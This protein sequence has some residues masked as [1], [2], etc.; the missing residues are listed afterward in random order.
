MVTTEEFKEKAKQTCLERYGVEN[1]GS[2][3]EFR[4]K[5]KQTCLERYGVEN[6]LLVPE[7]REKAKQTCLEKYGTENPLMAPE[8]KEKA[9]QTFLDKYG[10]DCSSHCPEILDKIQKSSFTS[11]EY[12]LPSGKIINIQGYEYFALDELFDQSISEE[13][14]V[15]GC[16]NVPVIKY[17]DELGTDRKHFPDIFIPSQN[18]C[19]EV[20]SP[21]TYTFKTDRILLKKKYAQEAGYN[22]EIWIYDGKGGKQVV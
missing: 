2:V 4:E 19:I 3:P 12:T 20:K 8:I 6:T 13:D 21:W 15:T 7:F 18:R 16:S 10:G 11:K 1:T 17:Q 14:I 22:Y 9:K 5:L